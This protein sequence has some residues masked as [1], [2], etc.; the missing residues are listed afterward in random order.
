MNYTVVNKGIN[1]GDIK[2]IAIASST[3]FLVGDTQIITA[4]SLFD[5]PPEAITRGPLVPLEIGGGVTPAV[6]PI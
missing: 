6:A 3:V 1:V 2:I 4:S 5:T